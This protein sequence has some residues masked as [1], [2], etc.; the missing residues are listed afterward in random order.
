TTR[1]S[2]SSS[3]NPFNHQEPTPPSTPGSLLSRYT[4]PLERHRLGGAETAPL[5]YALRTRK[6]GEDVGR[7]SA[8]LPTS[9]TAELQN[10]PR[11]RTGTRAGQ[12]HRQDKDASLNFTSNPSN[13]NAPAN[14]ANT[15]LTCKDPF[16][17]QY[18]SPFLPR[19]SRG[20][21]SP[22]SNIA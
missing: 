13:P 11:T 12:L 6:D 8:R 21:R 22:S 9:R 15:S 5:F 1:T 3:N 20:T 2:L 19:F 4:K 17:S 10:F 14:P 16:P 18:P 7:S